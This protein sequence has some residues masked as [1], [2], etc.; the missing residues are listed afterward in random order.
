MVELSLGSVSFKVGLSQVHI[1]H[2]GTFYGIS[3]AFQ[4][5]LS[6]NVAVSVCNQTLE[7]VLIRKMTI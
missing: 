4:K 3:E 2:T 1:V 5:A 6:E 7:P